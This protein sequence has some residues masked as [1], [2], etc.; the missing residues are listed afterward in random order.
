MEGHTHDCHIQPDT[1]RHKPSP[2]ANQVDFVPYLNQMS[3]VFL[4]LTMLSLWLKLA[5]G[6]RSYPKPK[7]SN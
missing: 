4:N 7:Q 2:N 3:T 6:R 5:K 1:E